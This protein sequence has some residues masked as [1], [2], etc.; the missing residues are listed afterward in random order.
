[1]MK[2]ASATRKVSKQDMAVVKRGVYGSK[3]DIFAICNALWKEKLWGLN[4]VFTFETI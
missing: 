1:M 2:K 3:E 4:I